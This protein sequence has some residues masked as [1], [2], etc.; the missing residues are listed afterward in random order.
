MTE[1][2]EAAGEMEAQVIKSLLESYGIPCLLEPHTAIPSPYSPVMN[3]GE[4]KVLVHGSMAD[5][6][7]KLIEGE[8]YA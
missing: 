6:A 7:R 5:R 2:Y 1:V 4:I 8:D 3:M